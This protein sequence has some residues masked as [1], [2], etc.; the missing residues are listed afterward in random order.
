SVGQQ[1]RG[2]MIDELS[3][4]YVRTLRSRGVS[5]RSIVF[6]Y[7]LRSAAGPGLT[8]LGLEF[9]GLISGAVIIEKIFNLPGIGTYIL[10]AGQQGDVPIIMGVVMVFVLIVL[11]V[12]IAIDTLNSALD[13]RKRQ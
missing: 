4:E 11:I 12:N 2:A 13:S 3:R 1:V 9:V 10:A 8:V 7:A 6:S 5:Q